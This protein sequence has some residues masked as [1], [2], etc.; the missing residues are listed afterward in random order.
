MTTD[1]LDETS[2]SPRLPIGNTEPEDR[3]EIPD[4]GESV[5]ERIASDAPP[6]EDYGAK[7]AAQ[8][9]GVSP[10]RVA[11]LAQDGRLEVVQER[12][13]RVSA[14]SVHEM[15]AARKAGGPKPAGMTTPPES[16]AEQVERLVSLFT[17]ESRRAITAQE[18]LLGE[19]TTQRDDLKSEVERLRG[20]VER[21]RARADALADRLSVPESP[22]PAEEKSSRSWWRLR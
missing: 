14:Q 16:V 18:H 21:E 11:Q 1:D 20:E 7:Q 19:V 10:R 5:P 3:S 6:G 4:A 22:A 9:L 17:A 12:P 15:R 13:L 2:E 8:V